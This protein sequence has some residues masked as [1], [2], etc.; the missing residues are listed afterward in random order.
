MQTI[1]TIL[2]IFAAVGIIALVLLQQGKGADAGAAFGSGGSGTVFGARGATSFLTRITAVL[3]VVFFITS[4]TL[5]YTAS[6]T[7]ERRSVTDSILDS[8][9]TSSVPADVPGTETTPSAS[10]EEPQSATQ[11]GDVPTVPAAGEK[12]QPGEGQ[13]DE[14]GS[15]N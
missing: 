14:T 13:K 9:T 3:A 5:A 8:T 12:S 10:G 2:H 4:L 1:I 7:V 15:S 11:P 6:R